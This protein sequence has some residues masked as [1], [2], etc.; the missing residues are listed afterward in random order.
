MQPDQQDQ[1]VHRELLEQQDQPDQLGPTGQLEHPDR[2]VVL[3]LRVRLGQM[4]PMGPQVFKGRSAQ[5]A[6]L[7]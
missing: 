6:Q 4:E 1:Q 5:Q 7:E 3:G 2:K